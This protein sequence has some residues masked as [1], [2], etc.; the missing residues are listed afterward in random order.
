MLHLKEVEKGLP[1]RNG[2]IKEWGTIK[3]REE[4]Q[5]PSF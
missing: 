2:I 5:L 3:T 4:I 1:T